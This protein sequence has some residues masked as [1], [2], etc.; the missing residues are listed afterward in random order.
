[1]RIC[2]VAEGCYPYTVGGISRW[3]DGLIRSFPDQEFVLLTIVANRDLRGKFM[4]ELPENVA[5]VY[6]L[7]LDDLDWCRQRKRKK[8]MSRKE[9]QSLRSLMIGGKI[10]WES[11]IDFF[12][13]KSGL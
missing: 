12:Q 11:L 9:Y 4:Y 2:I 3:A 6:E 8:R 7:Y 10:E 13:K 1:M 5:E